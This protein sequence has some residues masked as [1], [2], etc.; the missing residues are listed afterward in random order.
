MLDNSASTSLLQM[1]WG[2]QFLDHPL[3]F[4]RNGHHNSTARIVNH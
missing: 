4:R 3:R 1:F 2:Q